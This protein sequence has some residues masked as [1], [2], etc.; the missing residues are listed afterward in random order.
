[1]VIIDM[2]FSLLT[3][4]YLM[5]LDVIRTGIIKPKFQ[6]EIITLE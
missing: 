2:W 4:L 3:Y 1:M 5:F 6:C